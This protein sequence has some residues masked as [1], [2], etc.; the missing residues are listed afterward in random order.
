MP[1]PT[2]TPERAA[3][4]SEHH[5]LDQELQQHILT[6]RAQGLA[7]ADFARTLRDRRPA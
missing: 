3:D 4:Q 6:A 7:N 1:T 2:S 5:R